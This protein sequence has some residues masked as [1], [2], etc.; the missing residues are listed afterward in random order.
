[1]WIFHLIPNQDKY[2]KMD[3]AARHLLDRH[4]LDGGSVLWEWINSPKS[5]LSK[6]DIYNISIQLRT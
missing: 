5:M 2:K 6:T 1:M 4:L 3:I